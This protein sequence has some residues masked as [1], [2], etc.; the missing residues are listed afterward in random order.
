MVGK[1]FSMLFG[2]GLS[3]IQDT[4]E[5]FRPNAEAADQRSAEA[6]AV[7]LKQFQGEFGQPGLINNIADAANRMGRPLI[8]YA[9]LGLFTSAMVDPIWF[10]ARMQG[11]ALV[12][13]QLWVMLG[14]VVTFFFGSREM[15]K[16]RSGAMAKEAARIMAATPIVVSNLKELDA[17]YP[18]VAEAATTEDDLAGNNRAVTDWKIKTEVKQ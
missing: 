4:V 15:S 16:F 11:L 3:A 2:G 10:S 18:G 8:T 5:V 1:F 17:M 13:E 6:Q 9:V 7:A 12:P 14:I